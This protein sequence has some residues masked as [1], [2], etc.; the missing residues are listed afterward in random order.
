MSLTARIYYFRFCSYVILPNALI[1]L[2][3]SFLRKGCLTVIE[4]VP[5]AVKAMLHKVFGCSEIEPRV[6]CSVDV[7]SVCVLME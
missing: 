7:V 5:E 1:T 4:P 2:G 6:N 3:Y